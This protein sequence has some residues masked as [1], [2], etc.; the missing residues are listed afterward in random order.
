[1]TPEQHSKYLAWSHIAYGSIFALFALF[2]AFFF[3]LVGFL[4][5]GPG[6]PPNGP[7]AFFF[8]FMGL[9]MGLIYGAMTV[10]S[11]VAGFGLLKRRSWARTATIIA[12]VVSA[13][14]FP[15]GT[16]VCCYSFW[17][18]FS[19]PGKAIFE[20]QN[21]ALPPRRQE[22]ANQNVANQPTQSYAPPTTPPDWR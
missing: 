6:G 12:G 5:G 11:F 1:M 17:F 20:R 8:L 7:P 13:M 10:P 22:W 18:L 19:E 16:A 3:G 21:Y 9:F 2:F 4:G 14:S 15:L